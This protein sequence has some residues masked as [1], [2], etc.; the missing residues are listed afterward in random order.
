LLC[1]TTFIICTATALN[2]VPRSYPV[3]LSQVINN[4]VE[5]IIKLMFFFYIILFPITNNQM[6]VSFILTPPPEASF[7]FA[8]NILHQFN[9]ISIL[10][11]IHMETR[12][13]WED[14][15]YVGVFRTLTRYLSR[16]KFS[17]GI[18][19][20]AMDAVFNLMM[21]II[22]FY[23]SPRGARP[24]VPTYPTWMGFFMASNLVFVINFSLCL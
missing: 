8:W 19:H 3:S 21:H 12:S 4:C 9:C 5:T 18:L 2:I 7:T 20:T 11:Y 13:F 23:M 16:G 22:K 6:L 14:I 15:V 10:M 1:Y 17:W 24:S